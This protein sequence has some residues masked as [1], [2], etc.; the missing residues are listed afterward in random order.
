MFWQ[1]DHADHPFQVPDDIV[2]VLFAIDCKRLPVELIMPATVT[3]PARAMFSAVIRSRAR[4]TLA[5][6]YA[7]AAIVAADPA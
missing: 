2:D 6:R 1:E 5:P 7:P 3:K 4:L